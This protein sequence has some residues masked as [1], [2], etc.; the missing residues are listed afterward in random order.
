MPAT[1][2]TI[3]AEILALRR[4]HPHA[5]PVDVLD[6]VMRGRLGQRIDFGDVFPISDFGLI[7]VEAFDKGMPPG[8]WVS[9]LG[10][11]GDPRVRA[12]LMQI[13]ADEVWSAFVK[14]YSLVE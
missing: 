11:R 1:A 7:V 13:W 8:D 2:Q 6:L 12:T 4:S 14:R 9:L 10:P 5:S 3:V